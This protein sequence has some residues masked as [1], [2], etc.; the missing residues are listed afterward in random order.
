MTPPTVTSELTLRAFDP[1][2]DFPAMVGLITAVNAFDDVPYFPTVESLAVDWERGETFD[3]E[4][5]VR[6]A[7]NGARL[8]GA[9]HVEWRQRDAQIVHPIEIWVRPDARRQGIGTRLH[10]WSEARARA[11]VA[12]GSGGPAALPHVLSLGAPTHVTPGTA[13]AEA[14]GYVPVRYG[15]V[16]RRDLVEPI[17]DVPLPAGLELRPV[18]PE[19][20][21]PIG[22]ADV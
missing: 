17:P 19:D 16:M 4:G 2:T 6:L 22:D 11:V 12:A 15:F 5:D 9:A 20:H 13:F 10:D 14:R 8:V 1:A 21:R 3:P 18:A 7:F